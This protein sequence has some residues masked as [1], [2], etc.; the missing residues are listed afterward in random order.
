MLPDEQTRYRQLEGGA[1]YLASQ[2]ST[3][4]ERDVHLEMAAGY[5]SRRARAFKWERD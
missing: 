5:A 3:R 2:A 4:E 1:R